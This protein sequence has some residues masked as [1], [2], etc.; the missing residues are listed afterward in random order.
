MVNIGK[1]CKSGLG[2][3]TIDET[4]IGGT[5]NRRNRKK[6]NANSCIWEK[7][8]KSVGEWLKTLYSRIQF[9]NLRP[10]DFD[11]SF[12][13]TPR[14]FWPAARGF[15]GGIL[16]RYGGKFP[17]YISDPAPRRPVPG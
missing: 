12:R 16:Q 5:K 15:G 7:T 8:N 3:P 13:A 11:F 9:V 10:T 4:G 2:V 17:G 14:G 6:K 1:I